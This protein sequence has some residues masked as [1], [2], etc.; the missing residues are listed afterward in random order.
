MTRPIG[1]VLAGG[2]GRRLGRPKGEVIVRGEPLALRAAHALR[3]LCDA[4]LISVAPG[5]SNPAPP[6]PAIGDEGPS[7]R[8]PLAG[9][10]AAWGATARAADLLVLACDYPRVDTA[11]L[12][13]LLDPRFGSVDVV[14]PCDATGRDHPLV[15][16]WRAGTRGEVEAALAGG[17]FRVGAVLGRLVVARVD[18]VQLPDRELDG[19]LLNVNTARDLER[20]DEGA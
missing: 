7:G 2:A 1:V 5:A 10:A 6:Y 17:R 13:A 14:L 3:P 20:L 8:G 19:L 9:L 11:L 12:R 15:A 4:V 18:A 16:L